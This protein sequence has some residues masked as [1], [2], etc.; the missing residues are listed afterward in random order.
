MFPSHSAFCKA[1]D[2]DNPLLPTQKPGGYGGIAILF[3]TGMNLTVKRLP[4]GGSRIVAVKIQTT[5]PLCI[6]CVNMPSRNS[7]NCSSDNY[8]LFLDQLEVLITYNSTHAVFK[9]RDVN[10]SLVHRKGNLQDSLLVKFVET[11]SLFYQQDGI[12]TFLHP[13]KTDQAEIDCVLYLWPERL[14]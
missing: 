5:L 8:Q 3:R 2:D 4:V 9:L 6:C 10:A 7:K 12:E 14:P 11:N 1:V 13:N